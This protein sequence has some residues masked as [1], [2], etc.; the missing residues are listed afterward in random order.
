MVAKTVSVRCGSTA[1]E[2]CTVCVTV[3]A[4]GSKLPLFVIFKGSANGWIAK[5][6][7]SILPDGMYTTTQEKAWMDNLVM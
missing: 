2:I 5:E 1:N 4:D 3:A 6:L 7:L